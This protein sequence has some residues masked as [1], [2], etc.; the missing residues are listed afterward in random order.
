MPKGKQAV[1]KATKVWKKFIADF[2]S[3]TYM[4]ADQQA[5]LWNEYQ[6]TNG[7]INK[8]D[9][10]FTM[11]TPDGLAGATYG[12]LVSLATK[13]NKTI[14]ELIED[15]YADPAIDFQISPSIVIK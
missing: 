2:P 1:T 6:K 11:N 12:E 9:V 7:K 14:Y 3:L 5:I 13:H 8:N 15:R 4:P 10:Q